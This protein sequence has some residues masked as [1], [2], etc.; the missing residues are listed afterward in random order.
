M[1]LHVLAAFAIFCRTAAGAPA[2]SDDL[3]ALCTAAMHGDEK[4][5]GSLRDVGQ[6]GL[7]ALLTHEA[8]LVSALRERSIAMDSDEAQSLRKAADAVAR[9]RDAHASGL[10]WFTDLEAAKAEAKKSGK[11]ILSLR[12]LG[13]LDDEY[14]CANSRFFRTVLYANADVSRELREH[15]VL[16]WKSVRPV[17]VI[18]IDMGDGRRIRRTITGNSIHYVLDSDGVVLDALPG[19]YGPKAFLAALKGSPL[20]QSQYQIRKSDHLQALHGVQAD[21]LC[22]LWLQD[23]VRCGV[24]GPSM[25][26]EFETDKNVNAQASLLLSLKSSAFPPREKQQS[27]GFPVQP[28]DGAFYDA[29]KVLRESASKNKSEVKRPVDAIYPSEFSPSKGMVERPILKQTTSQGATAELSQA[30]VRTSDV[31]QKMR[32]IILPRAQ[33]RGATIEEVVEY[34]RTSAKIHDVDEPDPGR[35]G[36][37]IQFQPGDS[38]VAALIT[39][40][41]Q[42]ASFADV[43]NSAADMAGMKISVE[44]ARVTLVPVAGTPS[45]H[46]LTPIIADPHVPVAVAPKGSIPAIIAAGRADA[47]SMVE[48]PILKKVQRQ[49]RQASSVTADADDPFGPGPV[50]S[51]APLAERMT[52]ALWNQIALLHLDDVRLDL[53]SRRFM[54]SKLPADSITADERATGCVTDNRTAFARTL[55]RFEMSVAEDTVK[56]EY[57]FHTQIHQWLEEDKDGNLARD[58]EALNKRVYAELFLTPDYD[59]W[60][61]LVPEDTYTALEKDGCACDKGALPM[62][63]K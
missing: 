60:L 40:D 28:S 51:K 38:A 25:Q 14:S 9:Q 52:P 63:R 61:G 30:A 3:S 22:L 21:Q 11:Q 58:V 48:K 4:A 43:L 2:S 49:E 37:E 10:F 7:D 24:Y 55:R 33:F 15:Y 6:R 44:G 53:A 12:L 45:T 29:T 34:L 59:E 54:M 50:A 46:L 36:V 8:K 27:E 26:R 57:L 1:K 18:T 31:R 39:M 19:L 35:R 47:K 42:K 23:A 5:I 41:M 62:R 16:H 20:Q 32:N 13:N 17:P 56:N